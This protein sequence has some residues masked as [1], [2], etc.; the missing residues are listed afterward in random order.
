MSNPSDSAPVAL[1]SLCAELL[2]AGWVHDGGPRAFRKTPLVAT[3]QGD[4]LRVYLYGENLATGRVFEFV[5]RDVKDIVTSRAKA[6]Q[7]ALEAL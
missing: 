5:M 6:Y 7:T 3:V 1:P 4:V 2:A